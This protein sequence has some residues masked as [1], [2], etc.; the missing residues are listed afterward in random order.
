MSYWDPAHHGRVWSIAETVA[1][2]ALAAW[3]WRRAPRAGPRRGVVLGALGLAA[4]SYL[5]A[6]AYWTALFG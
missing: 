6:A 5:A 1:G 3:L 2:V 4:T